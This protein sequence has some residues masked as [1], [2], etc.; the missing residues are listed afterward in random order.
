M[1][2]YDANPRFNEWIDQ[3]HDGYVI[4]G[5]T[6]FFSRPASEILFEMDPVSYNAALE[7]FQEVQ[8]EDLKSSIYD[9]YPL[10]IAYSLYRAYRGSE[11]LHQQLHFLRD[12]WESLIFLL[13]A[14]VVGEARLMGVPLSNSGLR[15]D[16]L[17]SDRLST[18]LSVI[19]QVLEAAQEYEIDLR[20]QSLVSEE[21]V[22]RIRRLNRV[23]N[24]FSHRAALSEQQARDLFIE[25]SPEVLSVLGEID[26]LD[27][28]ILMRYAEHG[29]GIHDIRCE[30]F[31]GS[32]RVRE[33][34]NIPIG[35]EILLEIEYHLNPENILLKNQDRIYSLSP[36]VHFRESAAG[37]QTDLCLYKRAS[38]DPDV[39]DPP[40]Q[41]E[42]EVVGTSQC[43]YLERAQFEE[44]MEDYRELLRI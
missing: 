19:G 7:T 43:I 1:S 3:N 18:K 22:D 37:H 21:T 35:A 31:R 12:T 24:G 32:R 36:F 8:V 14:F 20:C 30:V 38:N 6:Y 23:R 15:M 9:S 2:S 42:F 26:S 5:D 40:P 17:R 44:A 29:Q 27:S 34:D 11:N 10:P 4:E 41:Y 28:L 39:D 13:Y 25:Y 16:D 33:F